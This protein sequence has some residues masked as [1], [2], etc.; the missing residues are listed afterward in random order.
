MELGIAGKT[1]LVTGA[2][3]GLGRAIALGLAHEG[4]RVV[5]VA[6]RR[7]LL[8]SLHHEIVKTGAPEPL[9]ITQEFAELRAAGALF[10]KLDV[11]GIKVDILV[12]CAGGSAPVDFTTPQ[13]EWR[14]RMMVNYESPRELTHLLLPAMRSAGWGRVLNVTGIGEPRGLNATLPAKAAVESWAKGLSREVAADGVTV[15]CVAPGR[16]HSGQTSRDFTAA[17]IEEFALREIPMG[18]FG[19]A[20]E[21]AHV[22]VFLA[23]MRAGYVTG[24][25]I[26]VDGGFARG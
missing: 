25:R 5:G 6:R 7:E 14:R 8:E 12:N 3:S 1:A 15:N 16:I 10:E 26:N 20:D 11:A 13:D 22:V 17:Q 19:D 2:S 24:A 21:F 9:T 4:V 23:S 18:R